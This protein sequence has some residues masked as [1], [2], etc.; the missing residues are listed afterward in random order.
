MQPIMLFLFFLSSLL[1][2]VLATPLTQSTISSLDITVYQEGHCK[3]KS[4]KHAKVAYSDLLDDSGYADDFGP[5][6]YR[7]SRDLK[8]D[9]KLIIYQKI[10]VITADEKRR[11]K[12]C[13]TFSD[14]ITKFRIEKGVAGPSIKRVASGMDITVHQEDKREDKKHLYNNMTCDEF[15]ST[16]RNPVHPYVNPCRL[17]RVVAVDGKLA[18]GNELNENRSIDETYGE[19]GN[20]GRYLLAKRTGSGMNITVYELPHCKGKM[21][22]RPNIAWQIGFSDEVSYD[23]KPSSQSFRLS[24]KLRSDEIVWFTFE[25]KQYNRKMIRNGDKKGEKGCHNMPDKK[26]ASSFQFIASSASW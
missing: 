8:A 18:S 26:K 23:D 20:K 16:V 11:N 24:R 17:N 25:G 13:H 14:S 5:T 10:H 1:A 22:A 15:N 7:L 19:F 2:I 4:N 6:S 9:E 3:G 12:G 21:H